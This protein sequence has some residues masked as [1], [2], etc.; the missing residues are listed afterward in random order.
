MLL[1]ISLKL[2]KLWKLT[3]FV[4]VGG[5]SKHFQI[6]LKFG[7]GSSIKLENSWYN[8][9]VDQRKSP[10]YE[11]PYAWL[12]QGPTS[13]VSSYK[14]REGIVIFLQNNTDVFNF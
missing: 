12:M 10:K 2:A 5:G 13:K 11:T 8:N 3:K 4:S 1:Y 14:R 6:W 9:K 7:M